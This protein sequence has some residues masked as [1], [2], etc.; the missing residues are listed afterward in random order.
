MIIARLP[1]EVTGLLRLVPGLPAP[2]ALSAAS[3]LAVPCRPMALAVPP[4]LLVPGRANPVKGRPAPVMGR[5]DWLMPPP[6]VKAP[7]REL[8][9]AVHTWMS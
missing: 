8:Q 2:P 9:R 3:R 6:C 1:D 4:R 7:G 5:T